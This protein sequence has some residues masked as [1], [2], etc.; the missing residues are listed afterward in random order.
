MIKANELRIGNWVKFPFTG[1]EQVGEIIRLEQDSGENNE[2]YIS[3]INDRFPR[4]IKTIEP[5]EI[6]PE[7]LGK[8]KFKGYGFNVYSALKKINYLH[9]LQNIYFALTGEEL[10]IEL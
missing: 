7:I 3:S 5:I 6:T 10:E 1:P 9:E 2:Y 4:H 8:V